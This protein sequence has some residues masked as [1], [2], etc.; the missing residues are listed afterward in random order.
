MIKY[1]LPLCVGK[2]MNWQKQLRILENNKQWDY[3]IA[4]M[5]DVIKNNADNM[6]AYIFMNYLF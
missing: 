2:Y 6:D 4:L 1:Y 3:A 5:Q